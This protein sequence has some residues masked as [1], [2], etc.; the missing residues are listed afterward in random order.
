MRIVLT[1]G[2][3]DH[4]CCVSLQVAISLGPSLSFYSNNCHHP[5]LL[6]SDI[7]CN[8]ILGQMVLADP[9]QINILW[10]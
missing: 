5:L 4:R 2:H 3:Q 7:T 1:L 9:F 6:H 8:G 10:I